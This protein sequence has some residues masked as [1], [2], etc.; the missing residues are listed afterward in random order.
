MNSGDTIRLLPRNVPA[1]R[2][3]GVSTAPV[4]PVAGNP[5][6]TR[7][8]SG[9]G[10]C[11]PGLECDL[12][13]L[14]R[15]F[16]PFL[17]VDIAGSQ[18]TVVAVDIAGAR[19]ARRAGWINAKTLGAYRVLNA[20]VGRK[21]NWQITVIQG[22]FGALGTQTFTVKTPERS[23]LGRNRPPIDNWTAVRLLTAD[24]T[25]TLTLTQGRSTLT[26]TGPR[27]RYLADDGSLADIFRPGE[28]T[29]SLCS[30]WTH[31]FR[32]CGCFYWAS[33][34]PDIAQ[35]P[36]PVPP[37][38]DVGWDS[39][40]IWE[41]RDRSSTA[42]P[43]DSALATAA[44]AD[45]LEIRHYEIN[46][47]WQELNFVVEGRELEGAYA[48]LRP[49]GTPLPDP[50][51]LRAHLRFGAGVELAVMHEYLAAAFSLQLPSN[52][53]GLLAQDVEVAQAEIMR[54]AIG[55]MRHIR[56]INDLLRSLEGKQFIPALRVATQ[57]PGANGG[58]LRNVAI[59]A[60]ELFVIDDFISIEAPSV[61]VDGYYTPILATLERDG[62]GAE[63][64]MIRTVMGEGA[65]H[66]DSFR[67]IKHWLGR[68]QPEEYL[69]V[70]GDPRPPKGHPAYAA[71]QVMYFSILDSLYKG[72]AAGLPQG[73][74]D[75]ND[76]R[77]SMPTQA[78]LAGAARM[79][80]D[81]GFLVRFDPIPDARFA[82]VNAPMKAPPTQ[83]P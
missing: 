71:L 65:D 53:G 45:D 51:T 77:T 54:I 38:D 41:R 75:I 15:R 17:E 63:A 83:K 5:V 67:F 23:S 29:Q 72:Y 10:T 39:A 76:A 79:V 33:N 74:P 11:Y 35:P 59:R 82:P 62:L 48:P 28:L 9:V 78:G 4:I 2:R 64:Q 3:L 61:S 56:A 42:P 80:A 25:V 19:A 8:E 43:G 69:A 50:D 32:D 30:P 6:S 57:I 46:S 14:E 13:N 44:S 73:A 55:E 52:L 58:A 26:L 21:G 81:A 34:H 60:A 37:S 24:S 27:A 7:L 66:W 18:I 16:F 1:Q 49:G 20:P 31:D 36:A 12:R 47:R 40:V 68:H 22:A 70:R